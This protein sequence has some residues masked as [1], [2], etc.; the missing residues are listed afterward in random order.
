MRYTDRELRFFP[1]PKSEIEEAF[2]VLTR[3]MGI[4]GSSSDDL[5]GYFG[6]TSDLLPEL[7]VCAL[8]SR[9]IRRYE[10]HRKFFHRAGVRVGRPRLAVLPVA[11]QGRKP[12]KA[13]GQEFFVAPHEGIYS[14]AFTVRDL[15]R[16]GLLEHQKG[17]LVERFEAAASGVRVFARDLA[18]SQPLTLSSDY[19]VLA[20]GT[21][22]TSRIVLASRNDCLSKLPL[23]DNP[24]SFIPFVDMQRIGVPLSFSGFMGAALTLVLDKDG[25]ELPVQ[26]SIYSLM[27]PLRTDMVREF[28][29]SFSGNLVAGRYLTPATLMLQLFYP[30]WPRSE[31]NLQLLPSGGLKIAHTCDSSTSEEKRLAAILRRA[32]YA[33]SSLLCKRPSAGSSIHYAGSLPAREKPTKEY[34]TDRECRLTWAP[35]VTIADASTFPVLPAK[36]HTLMLMANAFRLGR[37]IAERIAQQ[38]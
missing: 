25:L 38:L 26:G 18:T 21:I 37:E 29:L 6:S 1:F 33:A 34:E 3:H 20:A 23:L 12:F 16:K 7:E 4:S 9:F 8:A 27:G 28:P 17:I 11:H 30:D 35:G 22:N 13:F 2:D 24:V 5:A 15:V 19:L 10:R 32:G 36:N 14:P 31:N